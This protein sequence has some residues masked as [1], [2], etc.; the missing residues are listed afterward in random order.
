MKITC[1]GFGLAVALGVVSVSA[2]D[3]R[4]RLRPLP[5]E[6]RNARTG[7]LVGSHIPGLDVT[8]SNGQ[9]QNFETLRGPKGLVLLFARSADWS[10][11][12]QAQIRD[13]D[14]HASEFRR[15]GMGMAAVTYD[16]VAALQDFARKQ[17]ISM[18]LLSDPGSQTI[19]AFGLLN[20]NVDPSSPAFGV[21]FPG[22]Y[23]TG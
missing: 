14:R 19:K 16:S 22:T 15:K 7:P 20:G 21:P 9:R 2:A 18:P 6:S 13:L 12:C 10:P 11:V 17:A 8:D 5:A 3:D 4:P 23:I 1:I